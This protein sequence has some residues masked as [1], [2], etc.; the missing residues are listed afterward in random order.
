MLK[1]PSAWL[2]VT[3]SLA[4]VAI[5]LLHFVRYGLVREA[6]EG[7]SAHLFQILIVLQVPIVGY[8][9]FKWL[10]DAPGPASRVLALQGAAVAAAFASVYFLTGG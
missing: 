2:P 7:T 10:P 8:F 9:A 1:R 5:V 3:M 4:G 6:D